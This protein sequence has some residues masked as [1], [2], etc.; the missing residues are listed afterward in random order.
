MN[1]NITIPP[2]S[3]GG[4]ISLGIYAFTALFALIGFFTGLRRGFTKTVIRLCTVVAAGVIAYFA[5]ASLVGAFDT[6]FAGKTLEEAIISV[7]PEYETAVAPSTREIIA[8]F[9]IETA[10]LII[11][12][13]T[14]LVISPLLFLAAFGVCRALLLL[15]D[16]LIGALLKKTNSHKGALS[17][18][19]GGLVG[20]VQG[21]L[22]AVIVL[23]PISGMLTLSGSVKA[24]LL[25]REDFSDEKRAS[26]ESFYAQYLDEPIA[27][28]LVTLVNGYG[29]EKIYAELSKTK[30]GETT[31]AMTEHVSLA[32]GVAIDVA[33]LKGMNWQRPTPEQ[34]AAIERIVDGMGED[35]YT[36]RVLAGVLRGSSKALANNI[37]A[38]GLEAPYDALFTEAFAIFETSDESNVGADLDTML[39]VYFILADNELLIYISE[40]NTEGMKSKLTERIEDE[41]IVDNLIDTLQQNERTAPLVTLFTKLSVS[42]MAD[43][44]GLDEDTIQLYEGLKDDVNGV[45]AL[46]RSD[47]DTEEEYKAE[48]NTQLSAALESNGIL[49]EDDIV[50]GMTDY[51]A[52]NYSEHTEITDEM[53]NDAILSYYSSYVE[54]MQANGENTDNSSSGTESTEE[55]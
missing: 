6:A 17:T 37:S 9:D 3:I 23:I 42:I 26:V 46:N 13:V 15:V 51:V 19:T 30:I 33:E 53:V 5:A 54:F 41:L 28:P 44:L 22:I 43:Q 47:F 35:D 40:N 31:Y 20:I 8:A 34:E 48:V 24:D 55:Q 2:S 39:H 29:G 16:W 52:E 21:A 12:G 50:A 18:L 10:E 36:A 45:L 4:W 49:L 1:F 11:G 32:A 14:A 27:N 38:F 25:A 7:Y